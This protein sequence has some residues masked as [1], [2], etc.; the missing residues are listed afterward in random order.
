MT[1]KLQLFA[2]SLNRDEEPLAHPGLAF[3]CTETT[4][5]S[6]I[7]VLAAFVTAAKLDPCIT[8]P[9][10]VTVHE[11]VPFDSLGRIGVG[12]QTLSVYFT[13]EQE[14]KL[15]CKNSRLAGAVIAAQ[16]QPSLFVMKFFT[17]VPVEVDEAA[18]QRLPSLPAG[19]RERSCLRFHN[20]N[21]S[22]LSEPLREL[23]G[24]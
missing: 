15:Q 22:S 6:E 17:V 2:D 10:R 24:A 4:S 19:K 8:G 3:Y 21:Y 9:L 13:V 16:Q 7:V 12:F 5:E 1:H 23:L 18:A 11:Q 14:R 20:K